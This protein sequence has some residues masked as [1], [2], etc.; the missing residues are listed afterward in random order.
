MP[1][2]KTAA[3]AVTDSKKPSQVLDK[4]I[5]A[6]AAASK[7][8]MIKKSAPADGGMK[9]KMKFKSGTVAL[10]EVK[11]YQKSM[12]LLLPRAAFMRLVKM[13]CMN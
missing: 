1:K 9:K 6:A 8:K 12:D 2:T 11:R 13:F 7:T 4:K 3:K 5:K 10:R